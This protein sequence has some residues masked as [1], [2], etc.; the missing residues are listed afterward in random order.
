MPSERDMSHW[1]TAPKDK[2]GHSCSER[3]QAQRTTR[4]SLML[5]AEGCKTLIPHWMADR[6]QD[7]SERE[8]WFGLFRLCGEPKPVVVAHAACARM[9][10]S[11]AGVKLYGWM[12]IAS[13][14]SNPP[15]FANSVPHERRPGSAPIEQPGR[16]FLRTGTGNADAFVPCE[17]SREIREACASPVRLETFPGAGHGLS[18]LSDPAR[19]GRVVGEFLHSIGADA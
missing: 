17:M 19:Y 3:Q 16:I 13:I 9:R 1:P 15:A 7:P 6:E 5:Y 14:P 11:G 12:Y 4:E 18:Y 8:H 10:T 2:R